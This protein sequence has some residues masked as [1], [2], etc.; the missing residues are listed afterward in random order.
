VPSVRVIVLA[1]G[2][3]AKGV[4]DVV[5]KNKVTRCLAITPSHEVPRGAG[6]VGAP[7]GTSGRM[8]FGGLSEC[9]F[10]SELCEEDDG[11]VYLTLAVCRGEIYSG[12]EAET[13]AEIWSSCRWIQ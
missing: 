3:K 10:T 6:R 1:A 11:G 8:I 5:K 12:I 2:T 4:I 9:E 7:D 13:N